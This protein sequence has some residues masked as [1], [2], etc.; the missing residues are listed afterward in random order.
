MADYLTSFTPS[1]NLLIDTGQGHVA[2]IIVTSDSATPGAC[3]LYDYTGNG[4]PTGPV[5]ITVIA[6]YY[7]PI[8]LMMNDRFAPRFH[9]GLWLYLSDHCYL[10]LWHH[11]P[12]VI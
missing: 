3:T 5:L 11:M 8:I 1:Q 6:N 9:D 2:G 10:T 7:S 4:P 12:K